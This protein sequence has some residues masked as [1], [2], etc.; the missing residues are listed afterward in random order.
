MRNYVSGKS[1]N[2]LPFEILKLVKEGILHPLD[3]HG[4]PIPPPNVQEL[5]RRKRAAEDELR[6]LPLRY[7][8]INTG[9]VITGNRSSF[10][11]EAEL[12]KLDDEGKS[13]PYEI[14]KINEEL[15]AIPDLNTWSNY[16]LPSEKWKADAVYKVLMES[17]YHKDELP[18]AEEESP[19]PAPPPKLAAE[20]SFRKESTT[21]WKI[22]FDGQESKLIVNAEGLKY[23]HYLIQHP[24][25]SFSCLSL[26]QIIKGTPA[27]GYGD[28]MSE[29]LYSDHRR[30]AVLTP[31]TRR[32]LE[33]ELVKLQNAD[34]AGDPEADMI[35]R[36]EIEAIERTLRGEKSFPDDLKKKQSL[37]TANINKAYEKILTDYGMQKA[38]EHFRDNIKSDGNMGLMY[39]G[40]IV[41]Q[42]E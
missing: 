15:S 25:E 19:A 11:K 37:V 32:N 8:K 28:A 17:L 9:I 41:W 13:L 7:G 40:D 35:R 24:R 1:L 39:T 23:I 34:D 12:K 5:L 22:I 30:Q 20:Y 4:Q 16:E 33:I 10:N 31:A 18:K 2:L 14:D 3:Q 6:V 36:E 26:Y 27:E 29:G 42:T 38:V 21:H